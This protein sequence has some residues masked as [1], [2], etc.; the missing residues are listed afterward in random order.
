MRILVTFALP[1]EFASWRKDGGFSPAANDGGGETFCRRESDTELMVLLTGAGSANAAPLVRAALDARPF[2][3]VISSGLA[4]GLRPEHRPG[5]L[6][7]ARLVRRLENGSELPAAGEWFDLALRM[8]ARPAVFV[9]SA[10]LA[11]SAAEKRALGAGADAVD[12]ESF[13]LL[14][15]AASRR[16]PGIAIRAVSDPVEFDLP[17]DFNRVID[18]RGRVR[19]GP[20]AAALAAR[21][22]AIPGL[23]RLARDSR[24]A[25]AVLA[26][27]L[28]R[29]VNAA[30]RMGRG[31]EAG[32]S[33]G[34]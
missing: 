8:G 32:V 15:E 25:A 20:L 23:W 29:Y 30:A 21:P 26:H 31:E 4:G 13:A 7:A 34:T 28:E 12:M 6:L 10:G 5:A 24:R 2:D 33:A 27:F 19:A 14:A 18:P 22:A 11:A 16:T 9:S 17:L 1:E 3:L